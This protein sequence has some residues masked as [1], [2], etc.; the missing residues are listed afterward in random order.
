M[1]RNDAKFCEPVAG[2]AVA[3]KGDG[4][5]NV[6]KQFLSETDLLSWG[7][8]TAREIEHYLWIPDFSTQHVNKTNAI[9]RLTFDS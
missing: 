4:S 3:S 5:K 6:A 7:R 2:L 8:V 9:M 1:K